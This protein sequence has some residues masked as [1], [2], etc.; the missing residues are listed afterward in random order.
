M[1]CAGAAAADVAL[2]IPRA[3]GWLDNG[4]GSLSF[5]F[6]APGDTNLDWQ[7]DILDAANVLTAGKFNSGNPATWSQGDFNYDGVVNV[8]DA[9]DFL[10]TGLY[11]SG[12]YNPPLDSTVALGGGAVAA[13]PEP[14]SAWLLAVACGTLVMRRCRRRET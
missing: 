6:A 1:P 9:A 8:L 10:T 2:G 14:S 4:N 13:V 3:V 7:I 5:A 11:D 12:L